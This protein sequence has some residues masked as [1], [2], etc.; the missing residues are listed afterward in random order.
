M[1]LVGHTHS[2]QKGRPH[3]CRLQFKPGLDISFEPANIK[4]THLIAH[5]A[6]RGPLTIARRL[7]PSGR[8]V[9]SGRPCV[10]HPRRL[11]HRNLVSHAGGEAVSSLQ[12]L[13]PLLGTALGSTKDFVFHPLRGVFQTP[14][15][16]RLKGGSIN[17]QLEVAQLP[18]A[19]RRQ[20]LYPLP[21][22][23]PA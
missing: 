21:Y 15:S 4:T 17:S 8:G 19:P 12:T 9:P 18:P 23:I 5:H 13:I 2:G 20:V 6:G 10:F 11:S 1:W 3:F 22:F 14:H 7:A 16:Y